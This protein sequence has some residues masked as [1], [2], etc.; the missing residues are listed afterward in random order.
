MTKTFKFLLLLMA[1]SVFVG[2]PAYAKMTNQQL[3]QALISKL[4]IT[5]HD[6]PVMPESKT[7]KGT[8]QDKRSSDNSKEQTNTQASNHNAKA[9]TAMM[10]ALS[11]GSGEEIAPAM[12]DFTKRGY[13]SAGD[14]I[15]VSAWTGLPTVT[16]PL[17]H[18][19]GNDG[20]SLDVV[21]AYDSYS[22]NN[23]SK[24]HKTTNPSLHGDIFP[25]LIGG[26]TPSKNAFSFRDEEG[27]VHVMYYSS[28]G[29]YMS[30]DHWRAIVSNGVYDFLSPNGVT[31][32]CSKVGSPS[33]LRVTK[34]TSAHGG[35]LITYTWSSNGEVS[36][37][38]ASSGYK[39]TWNPND[40]VLSQTD[41]HSITLIPSSTFVQNGWYKI[42]EHENHGDYYCRAYKYYDEQVGTDTIKFSNSYYWKLSFHGAFPLGTA[43]YGVVNH[44]P[45]EYVN[46]L[47]QVQSPYGAIA[48]FST[49][50][51]S[52]SFR[53]QRNNSSFTPRFGA[54][55][56]SSYT[57]SGPGMPTSTWK[58]HYAQDATTITGPV[59]TQLVHFV[60]VGASDTP[61]VHHVMV[62][63]MN[64]G[65]TFFVPSTYTTYQPKNHYIDGL[66]LDS[67]V[68]DT[69]TGASLLYT[70]YQYHYRKLGPMQS[71]GNAPNTRSY[72]LIPY[73]SEA[74]Q[75]TYATSA[76]ATPTI[77]DN[78]EYNGDGLVSSETLGSMNGDEQS[79]SK[80]YFDKQY[81]DSA[82]M[83][84]YLIATTSDVTDGNDGSAVDASSSVIDE[85]G[86][87]T[88]NTHNGV[89]TTYTYG[90]T[91]N[92]ATQ[93]NA[94]GNTTSY[95][96]YYAGFAQVQIDALG[97]V[98]KFKVSPDGT[99][100]NFTNPAGYR[101]SY[102][103]DFL[104]RVIKANLPDGD[105]YTSS[106]KLVNNQEET[107]TTHGNAVQT[108]V[109]NAFG[110][111]ESI[112]V[113]APGI[114]SYTQT[115]QYDALGRKVFTSYPGDTQGTATTY[116]GL[117]RVIE[118]DWPVSGPGETGKYQTTTAY[119][120]WD[121]V[122]H[123]D[124]D[125]NV[126]DTTNDI[127]GS[128]D[129]SLGPIQIVVPLNDGLPQTTTIT[130]DAMGRMLSVEQGGWTRTYQY[131][132][133][134]WVSEID[135]PETGATKYTYDAIGEVLNSQ[136]GDS[137]VTKN[138]Y[139]KI[140]E[141]TTTTFPDGQVNAFT[142]TPTGKKA[143]ADVTGNGM[144]NT[145][146]YTYNSLDKL[147]S[148]SLS[149]NGQNPMTFKY[150]YD[151]HGFMSSATYADGT[152]VDYAPDSLGRPTKASDW[153][154]NV[155]YMADG[156]EKSFTDASG[157]TTAY[158]LNARHMI[159]TLELSSSQSISEDYHNIT[160]TYGYDGNAN[161]K[162]VQDTRPDH[163]KSYSYNGANWLTHA[164]IYGHFVNIA[165][166]ATGN[167]T[168]KSYE[169][170]TLNYS[171]DE[172]NRLQSVSGNITGAL[173]G[174]WQSSDVKPLSE[175]FSYDAYGDVTS[176]NGSGTTFTYNDA[177][178]L[179]TANGSNPAT[180]SRFDYQYYYDAMGNRVAV[181]NL[182]TSALHYE[183]YNQKNQLL[184]KSDG[185]T[186]TNY[187]Y[188]N[189]RKIAE[190]TH[191]ITTTADTTSSTFFHNDLQGSV[192]FETKPTGTIVD[193]D[194]EGQ[195]Y[196]PYG[197]EVNPGIYKDT[198]TGEIGEHI[199]FI[200][201][202]Y[203]SE[204][205]LSYFGARYY[206]PLI[207][208]FMGIDPKGF[209]QTRPMTFSRY[210]YAA[211][212]PLRYKDPDGKEWVDEETRYN[213]EV[214]L[215][216]FGPEFDGLEHMGE[217]AIVGGGKLLG[218]AKQ[219]Y[220]DFVKD[221]ETEAKVVT[222]GGAYGKIKGIAGNE[223]H[224]MPADSV[225]S[226]SSYSG[227][228]VSMSAADHAKTASYG[229]TKT[230]KGYRAMQAKLIAEGKFLEAQQMDISDIRSKFGS[231][232]DKGI[233]QMQAYTKKLL[234]KGSKGTGGKGINKVSSKIY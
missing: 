114:T 163:D 123:T 4:H 2:A 108:T 116:D 199:G 148:A 189:G 113:T 191:P 118:T 132:G 26:D 89:T 204:T 155:S 133:N 19:P 3:Q 74:T 223:A 110:K 129:N 215:D 79:I 57:K 60:P 102:R 226:Y 42:C 68:T 208:R 175:S 162:S 84:H 45:Y 70:K 49:S 6:A 218:K 142:Y 150:A 140:G 196:L 71:S 214:D 107:I 164:S 75:V 173:T 146:T 17:I 54:Y 151:S 66:T 97:H 29:H 134:F 220:N 217:E 15:A 30:R 76:G 36:I 137:G 160:L 212:N 177:K 158:T 27:N 21:Y 205:G 143:T 18:V 144:P 127:V 10:S 183:V 184:Y 138:T 81:K 69:K 201:K 40:H 125:H 59:K 34:I 44:P 13:S 72:Q 193:S 206:D 91:G 73:Q 231:K 185:Q 82:G 176:R 83:S 103:Y 14:N 96:D 228:A 136:V 122:E 78:Y 95:S 153:V 38:L 109:F 165:Y 64:G 126:I 172:K 32:T 159:Q 219:A 198:L 86:Y 200:N 222:K 99:V 92:L 61:E 190:S 35:E 43:N 47:T 85:N 112:T 145:W 180:G 213:I 221:S 105:I 171:Y 156:H 31:Y 210:A 181:E 202:P 194:G 88:S 67:L 233:Q 179:T 174:T 1:A 230:A 188:L 111:P 157:V 170:Q 131:N 51:T 192:I 98:S 115:D 8:K 168:S 120:S 93:T 7:E 141:L 28:N 234:G 195:T 5:D 211:D 20:L 225:S 12:P 229:S 152:E 154:T 94:L 161:I 80:S 22:S 16:I 65:I 90:P 63:I 124:A 100:A 147:K 87:T 77:T 121:Q 55:R 50:I 25:G 104:E 117:G 139:D 166:D 37:K 216:A 232:Y 209:D 135:N 203:N 46:Y 9:A 167:I 224:H 119:P 197:S 187:I 58:Y 149:I 207:G 128:W 106:Y 24:P 182:N 169:G 48:K 52:S 41:G 53:E 130:R 56:V 227:P 62:P 23:T 101:T 11:L 178:E 33:V 186:A 39:V